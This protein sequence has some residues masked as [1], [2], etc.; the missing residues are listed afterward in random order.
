MI[1]PHANR[2]DIQSSLS[3]VRDMYCSVAIFGE[4]LLMNIWF[5]RYS[6]SR[7]FASIHSSAVGAV[8]FIDIVATRLS[9]ERELSIPSTEDG[10]STATQRQIN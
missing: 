1:E 10:D 3:Y 6:A 5:V 8:R 2:R 4:M 9:R 7:A